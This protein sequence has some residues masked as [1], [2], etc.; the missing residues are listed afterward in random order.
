M[1][2]ISLIIGSIMT[3][4]GFVIAAVALPLSFLMP[5]RLVIPKESYF[6][7]REGDSDCVVEISTSKSLNLINCQAKIKQNGTEKTVK[8]EYQEFDEVYI[9]EIEDLEVGDEVEVLEI[10]ATDMYGNK[11]S[12][13]YYDE[14]TTE[15]IEEKNEKLENTKEILE[16]LYPIGIIMFISGA[17]IVTVSIVSGRRSGKEGKKSKMLSYSE[18]IAQETSVSVLDSGETSPEKKYKVCQYCGYESDINARK[19]ERCGADFKFTKKD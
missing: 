18:K 3:F 13:F 2:K 5:K 6:Y 12:L 7:Y 9:F 17:I 10:L 19:C 4:L 16:I 1:K 8:L 11:V 15:N 14:I